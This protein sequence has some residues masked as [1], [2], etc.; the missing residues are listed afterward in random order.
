[1][2]SLKGQLVELLRSRDKSEIDDVAA[3]LTEA[4]I[5][6]KI[7]T[8]GA[9]FDITTIGVGSDVQAI[10]SVPEL[11]FEDARTCLE[12][13]YAEI[14]LPDDHYLHEFSNDDLADLLANENDWSAYDVVHAR[15]IAKEK[16]LNPDEIVDSIKMNEDI[17]AH[18]MPA[19]KWQVR[20]AIICTILGPFIFIMTVIAL[21]IGA[22]FASMRAKHPYRKYFLY[23]KR[24]ARFG[25]TIVFI[26][27]LIILAL[28][29][30]LHDYY[31]TFIDYFYI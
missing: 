8:D 12:R 18:G 10:I 6:H 2:D 20:I 27:I 1:M 9:V 11:Q 17:A 5:V 16:K 19:P 7:G 15:R 21:C 24:S 14:P 26:N 4:N 30:G 28:A 25:I 22:S 3:M 29:L 13:N 31:D 23:D